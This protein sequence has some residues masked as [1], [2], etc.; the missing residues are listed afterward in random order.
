MIAVPPPRAV[1]EVLTS[2]SY[3]RSVSPCTHAAPTSLAL[4]HG[5]VTHIT[6]S[7]E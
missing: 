6:C 1:F 3:F 5:D 7:H 2:D 4:F